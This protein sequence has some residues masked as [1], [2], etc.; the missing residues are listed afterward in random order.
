MFDD[1][2]AYMVFPRGMTRL[3]WLFVGGAFAL[4]LFSAGIATSQARERARDF[5]RLADM[6]RVQSALELY[7]NDVNAYPIANT[8]IELG[9]SGA[10]CLGQGGLQSACPKEQAVYLSPIPQ[11][12]TLGLGSSFPYYAYQSNGSTYVIRLSLESGWQELGVAK[13]GVVCVRSGKGMALSQTG[14]CSLE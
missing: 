12:T 4:V 14:T 1:I 9:G 3:E 13:G 5:K 2:L 10:R 11:Q 6:V 7:F 8:E